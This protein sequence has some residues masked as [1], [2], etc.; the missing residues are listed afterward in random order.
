MLDLVLQIA[1]SGAGQGTQLEVESEFAVLLPYEVKNGEDG[2]V[3]AAPKPAAELLKEDRRALRRPKED[4]SVDLGD[5][6]A[7]IEKIDGENAADLARNEVATGRF[8]IFSRRFAMQCDR[9]KTSIR[10]VPSHVLGMGDRDAEA[11]GLHPGDVDHLVD[12][13]PDHEVGARVVT[14][15]DV[16]KGS[17]VVSA[18]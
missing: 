4:H 18:A 14:G 10:E 7:F 13:L 15:V 2:L 5:I 3:L 6:N 11:Q 9:G 12:K 17:R 8:S 16:L 1:T